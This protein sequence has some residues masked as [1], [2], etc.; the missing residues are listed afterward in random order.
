MDTISKINKYINEDKTSS[1]VF[2]AKNALNLVMSSVPMNRADKKILGYAYSL[3]T[4]MSK[5]RY[6]AEKIPERFLKKTGKIKD[7]KE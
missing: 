6:V 3:L 2:D 1:A 5:G 4:T 7:S